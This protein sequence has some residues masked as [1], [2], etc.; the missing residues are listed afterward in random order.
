MPRDHWFGAMGTDGT[1]SFT[2]MLPLPDVEVTP[3]L[4][5]GVGPQDSGLGHSW[6]QAT[7]KVDDPDGELAG[8]RGSW[9]AVRAAHVPQIACDTWQRL[10]LLWVPSSGAGHTS[11]A[12]ALRG[13]LISSVGPLYWHPEHCT[14]S[15][16][17]GVPS[18]SLWP[19]ALLPAHEL[20][21]NTGRALRLGAEGRSSGTE[22]QRAGDVWWE[23]APEGITSQRE[24]LACG[25]QSGFHSGG[26]A[27]LF[28]AA[29]GT[30]QG[31]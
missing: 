13:A 17:T 31:A 15:S 22:V 16:G 11:P 8:A 19:L 25:Q 12:S 3:C 23:R 30:S 2:P 20:L 26:R 6:L 9:G 10:R 7:L 1:L 27:G 5:G 29:H 28:Y 14:E 4:E 18:G 24:P 21:Q